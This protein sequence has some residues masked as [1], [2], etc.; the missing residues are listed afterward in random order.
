MNFDLRTLTLRQGRDAGLTD[1]LVVLDGRIVERVIA[2]DTDG[3]SVEVLAGQFGHVVLF[4]DVKAPDRLKLGNY[5]GLATE[6][7]R[8]RT[9][10]V[11]R[12][13][14]NQDELTSILPKD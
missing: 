1:V 13:V 12:K 5:R 6:T 2:F 7:R 9:L 10:D 8:G 11:Y 4:E 3:P 14:Q